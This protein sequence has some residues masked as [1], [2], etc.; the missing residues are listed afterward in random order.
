MRISLDKTNAKASVEV[1]EARSRI[2]KEFNVTEVQEI[3]K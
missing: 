3:Q 2:S 1:N